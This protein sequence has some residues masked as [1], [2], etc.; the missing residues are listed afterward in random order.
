MDFHP[1]YQ[2]PRILIQGFTA[3]GGLPAEVHFY[4]GELI[5]HQCHRTHPKYIA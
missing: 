1:Q 3:V 4:A 2:V 5:C